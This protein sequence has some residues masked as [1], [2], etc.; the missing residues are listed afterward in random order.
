[1]SPRHVELKAKLNN[2]KILSLEELHEFSKTQLATLLQKKLLTI[3]SQR[4]M[5]V[6]MREEAQ[7]TNDGEV[8]SLQAEV[9]M[10]TDELTKKTNSL[11]QINTL[12]E[13]VVLKNKALQAELEEKNIDCG[14]LILKI[15]D[16]QSEVDRKDILLEKCFYDAV[17]RKPNGDPFYESYEDWKKE[18]NTNK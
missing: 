1:M 10:V 16:L 17:S 5:I 15:I 7:M 9:D 12:R 13:E 11:F 14:K 3:K 2:G 6:R 18:L 8:I 4:E